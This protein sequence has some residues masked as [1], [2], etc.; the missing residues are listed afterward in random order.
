[1]GTIAEVISAVREAIGA[2]VALVEKSISVDVVDPERPAARRGLILREGQKFE[3]LT[4][5][6]A[7]YEQYLYDLE[8]K[9]GPGPRRIAVKHVAQTLDGFCDYV[10]RHKGA[11]TAISA[12]VDER[13]KPMLRAVIDFHGE[14]DGESGPDPRWCLH[15]V[16][17]AFPFA[18][19]FREWQAAASPMD[20]KRFLDWVETH[21][22]ELAHPSEITEAG[23]LTSDIF[24]KVLI[25]KGFDKDKRAAMF[26]KDGLAAVFGGANELFAGAKV[27]NGSTAESLEETIDD[28]GQV[29]IAY[30]RADRVENATAKRYYLADIKVFDGD[31][32]K[33]CVPVR[34]DLAVDGGKLALS[35]HL[36]G[37]EQL[38][39]A[40]FNEACETVA[41]ATGI[42]PIRAVF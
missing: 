41:E 32:D 33:R 15:T 22:V 38:V 35:L 39:E 3:D 4:S 12:L 18:R 16:E 40:S 20:K 8:E 28:M 10:N 24:H 42:A 31:A 19:A 7:N 34:L 30:K 23:T 29:S 6:E 9:R 17:Y 11:T 13:G 25:V 5:L 2:G 27:M 1:M 37:V 26:A 14:S 21:A 36:I